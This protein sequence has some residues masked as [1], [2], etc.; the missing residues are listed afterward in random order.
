MARELSLYVYNSAD[1]EGNWHGEKFKYLQ[2]N[3]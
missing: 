2:K 1:V 3:K